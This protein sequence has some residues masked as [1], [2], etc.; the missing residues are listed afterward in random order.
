MTAWLLVG[1]AVTIRHDRSG[2]DRIQPELLAYAQKFVAR[3]EGVADPE[4]GRL[5]DRT[6]PGQPNG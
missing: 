6:E 4:T 5:P 2:K 3:S 1:L